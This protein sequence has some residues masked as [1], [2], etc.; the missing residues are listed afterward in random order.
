MRLPRLPAELLL[1]EAQRILVRRAR[2]RASDRSGPGRNRAGR[3]VLRLERGQVDPRCVGRDV[4]RSLGLLGLGRRGRR[5]GLGS[6][7][8]VVSGWGGGGGGA[9]CAAAAEAVPRS[10]D[11]TIPDTAC[12]GCPM[13]PNEPP[14]AAPA[15][16][17]LLRLVDR[18][19]DVPRL[20][21]R[22]EGRIAHQLA[23]VRIVRQGRKRRA[24]LGQNL[25]RRRV[26][27]K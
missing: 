17:P 11:A 10:N 15:A 13:P 25:Q 12:R 24:V 9:C 26:V 27:H 8:V 18:V 16:R 2:Y 20:Q 14:Q 5:L 1:V 19:R 6:T 3:E 22:G 7:T 23:E 4:R 21:R